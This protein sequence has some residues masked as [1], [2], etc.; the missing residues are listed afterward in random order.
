MIHQLLNL[1]RPLFV[2]DT[3]TTGLDTAK[4]RIVELGFQQWIAEGMTKE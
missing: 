4:D 1:T 3:E 2:L